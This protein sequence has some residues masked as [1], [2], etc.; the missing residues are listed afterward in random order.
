MH[1]CGFR[2]GKRYVVE[3]MK[4]E[5]VKKRLYNSSTLWQITFREEHLTEEDFESDLLKK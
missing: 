5:G 1:H 2:R 3:T 4:G